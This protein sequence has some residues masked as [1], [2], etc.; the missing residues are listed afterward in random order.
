M[1]LSEFKEALGKIDK[2]EFFL[3]NKITIPAHFHI[4]E[5]GTI[6]KQF[7]DCGGTIRCEQVIGF[8]IWVAHDYEHRLAPKKLLDIINIAEERLHLKDLEIEIEYQQ[9]TIEKYGLRFE[10]GSFW[11]ST[12][13]KYGLRFEDGSFWLQE[14]QTDCL[15]KEKCGIPV[16]QTNCSGPNCC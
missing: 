14:K 5:V 15:A 16:V 9:S 7:I 11:Q 3:P 6:S 12:I 4:T 8:Q 1:K 10:D 2:I 13:E